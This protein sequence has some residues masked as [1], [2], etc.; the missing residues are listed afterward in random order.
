MKGDKE[1][2]YVWGLHV[3]LSYRT[4]HTIVGSRCIPIAGGGRRCIPRSSCSVPL[5]PK[6]HLASSLGPRCQR[7]RQRVTVDG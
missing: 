4:E 2:R 5:K 6:P 1:R 3:A 7:Q